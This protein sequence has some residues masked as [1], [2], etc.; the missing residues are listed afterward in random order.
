MLEACDSSF[1]RFADID[2]LFFLG[3]L[4]GGGSVAVVVFSCTA[5]PFVPLVL[6]ESVPFEKV[7]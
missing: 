1:D 5:D 7:N 2:G 6:T 3:G 4:T